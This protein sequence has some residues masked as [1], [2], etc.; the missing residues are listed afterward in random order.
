LAE[1]VATIPTTSA[2]A[3]EAQAQPAAHEETDATSAAP[4]VARAQPA[5]HEETAGTSTAPEEAQAQ[6]AGTVRVVYL[7]SQRTNIF[8]KQQN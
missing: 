8:R 2:V 6:P 4:E 1:L 7:V 5:A 3:G